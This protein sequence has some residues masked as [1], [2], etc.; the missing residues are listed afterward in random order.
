[1]V[2]KLPHLAST[3]LLVACIWEGFRIPLILLLISN[4]VCIW[5]Q[6]QPQLP[7]SWD[8]DRYCVTLLQ[9]MCTTWLKPYPVQSATFDGFGIFHPTWIVPKPSLNLTPTPTNAHPI[10]P[11]S[12]NMFGMQIMDAHHSNTHQELPAF[13]TGFELP[14]PCLWTQTAWPGSNPILCC[15]HLETDLEFFALCC[16]TKTLLAPRSNNLPWVKC[17]LGQ[18]WNLKPCVAIHKP[19]A[20]ITPTPSHYAWILRQGEHHVLS[21]GP[22]ICMHIIPNSIGVPASWDR[23]GSPCP[24]LPDDKLCNNSIQI[25]NSAA[26]ILAQT[27]M[28][29]VTMDLLRWTPCHPFLLLQPPPWI[30]CNLGPVWVTTLCNLWTQTVHKS[31]SNLH[32]R[33]PASLDRLFFK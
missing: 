13:G 28:N 31:C 11:A 23:F 30:V 8:S 5:L 20:N 15:L 16:Q 6:P 4:H 9:M 22:N 29:F 19:C 18:V 33:L 25:P 14:A 21:H 17:I 12:W 27:Q 3:K 26:C 7:A 2:P 24:K 32:H 1:M 10:L